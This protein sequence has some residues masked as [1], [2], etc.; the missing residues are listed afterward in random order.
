MVRRSS[1]QQDRFRARWRAT[2]AACAICGQAIDFDIK[3]PD[4]RSFVVDHITPLAKGGTHSFQNTQPAH[5]ECNSKKRA[6]DA[7]PIVR[8]SGAL[9]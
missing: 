3:W 8:R 7:A 2:R 1:S 5:A 6:R 9:E 4:P